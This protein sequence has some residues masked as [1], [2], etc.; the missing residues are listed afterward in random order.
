MKLEIEKVIDGNYC[1]GCGACAYLSS[2]SMKIN[3]YGEYEPDIN[4]IKKSVKTEEDIQKISFACPSLNPEYNEDNLGKTFLTTAK[5]YDSHLGYYYSTYAGFVK[6]KK[7]RENGTSGGFGTWIATELLRNKLIDAVI[8]IKPTRKREKPQDPFFKYELSKCE[9]E[10]INGAKTRYHVTEISDALNIVRT[11]PGRYLFVGL[12]CM[13]KAVRRIQLIDPTIN[14]CIKYTASLVCGHL[15]SLNWTLSLA[16]AKGLSPSETLQIDSFT[17][18]TKAK[19][20]PIKAYVY[21]AQINNGKKKIQED[22][23]NVTGGKFNQGA[24]MLPACN[25]CDDVVGE[26]ADITI[27]DAWLPKY[28]IDNKGTNLIIIR[29][30]TLDELLQNGKNEDRIHLVDVSKE[31]AIKSQ[32]G[33]FRQ[34]REGLAYRLEHTQKKGLWV[35]EKRVTPGKKGIAPLRKKIYKE[36]FKVTSK[37]RKAFLKAIEGDNYNIYTSTM[38]HHLK[39]LRFLEVSSTLTRILK[40]RLF[41][42]SHR[43]KS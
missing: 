9:E 5:G 24:L 6:E 29:N 25:F 39:F 19:D 31:D 4:L 22:T 13:I 10:I 11:N 18:R 17:Y 3:K 37:S 16:W 7:F 1:M 21:S 35:P 8:H 30:K 15:K 38:N 28:E 14:Q 20:I 41:Y 2:S 40:R 36:R 32:S 12:P 27:G 26:T 42:I 43:L 34:R 23:S 33:G